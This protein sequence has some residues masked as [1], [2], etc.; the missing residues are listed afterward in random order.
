MCCVTSKRDGCQAEPFSFP[1]NGT[2][3][4]T[5]QVVTT[6]TLTLVEW[7]GGKVGLAAVRRAGRMDISGPR[8]LVRDFPRWGGLSPLA[9]IRS[10][11]G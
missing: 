2:R 3:A 10:A 7:Q 9:G 6:D 8:P 1:D 11:V 4:L 5:Y